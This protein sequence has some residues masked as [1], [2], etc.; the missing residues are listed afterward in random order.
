M[1]QKVLGVRCPACG[2]QRSLIELMK[3]DIVESLRI[4]PPLIPVLF[5]FLLLGLHLMFRFRNGAYLL[6]ISAM[7]TGVIMVCNYI[8][9]IVTS[10]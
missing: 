6:K 10:L 2:L 3:G 5:L 9:V 1:Y 4:Y 7:V 8:V